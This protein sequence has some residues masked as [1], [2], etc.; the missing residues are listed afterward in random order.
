[1]LHLSPRTKVPVFDRSHVALAVEN[2]AEW[3][4]W[5][6]QNNV[7]LVQPAINICQI[8]RQFLRDPSGNLIELVEARS[9]L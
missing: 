6:K 2:V 7:E 3:I 8:T 5:L 4:E 1:M 9:F